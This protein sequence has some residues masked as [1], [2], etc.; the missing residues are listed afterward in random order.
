MADNQLKLNQTTESDIID[1]LGQP[2]SITTRLENEKTVKNLI[3][4][5]SSTL[6]VGDIAG[7]PGTKS[8]A[9][10][11]FDGKLVG[12]NYL[13]SQAVDSMNFNSEL[14]KNFKE[15]VTTRS[16][17]I[18]ALGLPN[19]RSVYP[20]LEDPDDDA[21]RYLYTILDTTQATWISQTKDLTLVFGQND[22]VKDIIFSQS[23]AS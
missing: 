18:S 13:S 14:V 19:G 5:Y 6:S 12:Y 4:T 2:H 21:I 11:F 16:D 23:G 17:V 10:A 15:G 22:V 1:T 20:I 7:V 8:Q 9:F 3:Y